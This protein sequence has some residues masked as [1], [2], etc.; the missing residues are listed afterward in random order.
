MWYCV[1]LC[2]PSGAGVWVSQCA[3]GFYLSS[4]SRS[5]YRSVSQ[6]AAAARCGLSLGGVSAVL[7]RVGG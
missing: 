3:S 2:L 7:V 5:L 6:A 4:S 1:R